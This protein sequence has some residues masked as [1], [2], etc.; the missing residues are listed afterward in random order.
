MRRLLFILLLTAA[1]VFLAWQV[2]L[3]PGTVTADIGSLSIEMPASVAGIGL[4]LLLVLFYWLFRSVTWARHLP[5]R[6]RA[7]RERSQRQQ[8][9]GAVTRALVALAA[10]DA[11]A[12]RREAA[13]A[14]K[15]LG[16]SAQTLL[17]AAEAGRLA[18]RTDE[19]EGALLAL[20]ARKDSAFLGLRGLLRDAM[21]RQAWVE[22]ADLARRA[23]AA[24]PGAAWLRAERAQL[25]VRTGAW[26]EA[27]GL[28]ADTSAKAALAAAAAQVEHDGGKALNLA[29]QAFEF[30]GS[31]TPAALEY[32]TRLRAAGR[33][34]RAQAVLREAWAKAP[35]QALADLALAPVEDVLARARAAQALVQANPDDA[36]SHFLLART[37]FAAK[38]VGEARRH[39]EAAHAAGL[40]QRRLWSLLADIEELD[41]GDT[42]AGRAAQR[43]ALKRAADA[44][45]N[46]SWLC[47]AC[48]TAHQDWRA[49]CTGCGAT[50]SL[51]W[52]TPVK[53]SAAVATISLH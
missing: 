29:R 20:A 47:S 30:D 31:L 50:G 51:H 3:L 46:A 33:E 6:L 52:R 49:A 22:A 9:D 34:R 37:A 2:L 18:G 40:N 24:H 36:E 35:H 4:L 7:R 16:E 14:R 13:Q 12:A 19:T 15:L 44:E 11:P 43:D 48:G 23:E 53:Q 38:L 27:L 26:A 8:G 39:V 42:E 17:L 21:A 10:G 5:R 1:T 28:T 25:A 41:R 45:E 32:A